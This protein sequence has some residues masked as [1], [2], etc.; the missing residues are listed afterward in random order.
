MFKHLLV[1]LDGSHLAEAAIPVASYLAEMFGASVML[2]HVIE[3]DAPQEIHSEPHLTEPE[4]AQAYLDNIAQSAF[5]ASVKVDRHVHTSAVSD[6]ARSIA[7]HFE[8]LGRP[9][10]I[11]MCTHGR[12]GP[13]DWLFGSIAQQV[14]A[15]GNAPVLLVPPKMETAPTFACHLILVP[16][17]GSPEHEQGLPMA[18]SLAQVC[19]AAL[20][21]LMVIPTL[22]TLKGEKAAT[23]RMLPG[24]MM[25]MLDLAEQGGRDYLNQRLEQLQTTGSH[26][27]ANVVRGDPVPVIV[28]T[29]SRLQASLIVFGTHGKSGLEAFWSGSVA[30]KVSGRSHVPLLLVP[31]KD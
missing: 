7:E 5:P 18:I 11:I 6:V 8:E 27:S 13:R 17:D 2:I 30:P 23:G 10:L 25:A 28:D 15:L 1:P 12:S 24:A 4:E 9:D 3:R 20:H 22:G 21:L 31:V 29:A 16:L 19:G 26:L 14:I